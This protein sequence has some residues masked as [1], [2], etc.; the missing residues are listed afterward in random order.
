MMI[1]IAGPYR[2]GTS[3]DAALMKKNLEKLKSVALPIFQLGHVPMIGEWVALPLIQLNGSKKTGDK[4]WDEIQYPVAHRLL[5]KCDAVFRM[6][7]ASTGADNDVKIAKERGL[8]IFY[9][10]EEIPANV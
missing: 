4:Q 10:L 1:L 2:S 7:G 3:D 6:E 8:K 9:R 5:E